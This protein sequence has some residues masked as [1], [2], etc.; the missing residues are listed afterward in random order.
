MATKNELL[1]QLDEIQSRMSDESLRLK[2]WNNH[3]RLFNALSCRTWHCKSWNKQKLAD[4]VDIARRAA[5][6]WEHIDEPQAVEFDK[7]IN[8]QGWCYDEDIEEVYAMLTQAGNHAITLTD[9][10]IAT[11]KDALC[12]IVDVYEDHDRQESANVLRGIITKL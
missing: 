3:V 10:E 11:L 9:D 6:V 12:D 7:R 1:A 2:G 4:M 8:F 5:Y